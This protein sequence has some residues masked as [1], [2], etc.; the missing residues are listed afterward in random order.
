M[1]AV[2][3]D[4]LI[5]W[6][7]AAGEP[8][9]LRLLRLCAEKEL[10]VSDLAHALGQSE[11]RVS[12]HLKILC[13]AGLTERL[14][15][16]QWVHYR[17]AGVG[18]A[19]SFVRGLLAQADPRDPQLRHDRSA[20]RVAGPA[21]GDALH[22]AE[23]RLGRAL[24]AFVTGDGADG[25]LRSG[26][27]VGSAHPELLESAAR[28]FGRLTALV[29]SRRAAQATLA[30]AQRRGFECRVVRS[31]GST[32]A[33]FAEFVKAGASFDALVLDHPAVSTE[34]LVRLLAE[35]RRLVT[36]GGRVWIFEPYESLEG[37][38]QRVVEHPLARLRRLLGAAGLECERLSPIEADGEHVLAARAASIA[39]VLANQ[40]VAS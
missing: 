20:A 13:E 32:E 15:Q 35:V 26:L 16:G 4:V 30:Y 23:S 28:S 38:R 12:R 21:A 33:D 22:A 17:I 36:P 3:A 29:P 8:S 25:A 27:I 11:P 19:T 2:A 5:R 31:S 14:P 7:R 6:L 1:S 10:S 34:R 39:P 40:G 37:P 18:A 9:R 24:A